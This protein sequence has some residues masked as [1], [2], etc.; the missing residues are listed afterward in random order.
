MD[1]ILSIIIPTY[2]AEAYLE[3]CLNSIILINKELLEKCEVIVIN[4]GTPDNSAQIAKKFVEKYPSVCK[5]VNKENGG[6]GSAINTGVQHI[7]GKYFKVLDA[8][9]WV[10]SKETEKTIKKLITETADVVIT[11]YTTY[12]IGT[13]KYK[14]YSVKV[15]NYDRDYNLSELM[16]MWKNVQYGMT[17]HGIIYKKEFYHS[18]GYTLIENVYYEDQEYATIPLCYT[19]NIHCMNTYMYVYRIGDVN[20]SVS[21]MNQI[22]RL[23]DAQKVV[24]RMLEKGGN[25]QQ[26]EIG[27]KE[28]WTKK[29]T[30]LINSYYEIAL[31]KKR[32]LEGRQNA[33]ILER[34][35][36]KINKELSDKNRKKYFVFLMLNYL[37]VRDKTY[38]KILKIVKDFL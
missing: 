14:K 4:D 24:E 13:Q 28:Y 31:L 8:D 22:K 17:F 36:K 20:Q 29:I 11:G 19:K 32:G 26:F 38:R 1:K 3:K 7:T 25:C 16:K 35:V 37:G 10:N 9:D 27:G 15:N 30:M 34:K 6:H 18:L 2:N 23:S 33:R 21:D 5:L 12:H